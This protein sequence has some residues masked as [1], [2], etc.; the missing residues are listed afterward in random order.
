MKN[1][2]LLKG[3]LGLV[4]AVGIWALIFEVPQPEIACLSPLK[5]RCGRNTPNWNEGFYFYDTDRAL[6]SQKLNIWSNSTP[7]ISFLKM[8][9]GLIH[10]VALPPTHF[11]SKIIHLNPPM[12]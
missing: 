7:K 2:D 3:P 4:R 1:K 10:V 9:V 6:L 12:Q 8:K 5:P 11:L